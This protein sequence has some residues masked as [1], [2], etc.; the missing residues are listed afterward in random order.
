ME[1]PV[2]NNDLANEADKYLMEGD[3][4]SAKKLY[5]EILS[6]DP[7]NWRALNGLGLITSSSNAQSSLDYFARAVENC[8][9]S[10]SPF[11]NLGV[12][13][14]K[15]GQGPKAVKAWET[16]IERLGRGSKSI[17]LL[18]ALGL[19]YL[20]GSKD[21]DKANEYFQS[22]REIET[23][24]KDFLYYI[25]LIHEE[26]GNLEK[27]EE[28]YLNSKTFNAYGNL[29]LL[30]RSL[31]RH[32]ES[33]TAFMSALEIEDSYLVR[34]SLAAIYNDLDDSENA[35]VNIKAG[36]T[37]YPHSGHI[38]RILRKMVDSDEDSADVLA[39]LA[40]SESQGRS[41]DKAIS[42]NS[43]RD[44]YDIIND[45]CCPKCFSQLVFIKQSLIER[46]R[47]FYD[48]VETACKNCG[49]VK[50]FWFSI[51]SFFP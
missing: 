36:L 31:N 10:E 40:E 11:I 9:E 8:Y 5:E 20:F 16:G 23:E 38:K 39:L 51:Q 3:H 19:E 28:F 17:H 2:D 48:I 4:E 15:L 7:D 25:G 12:A 30:Y 1:N 14:S 34:F 45:D 37:Q 33:I 32:S 42:V 41:K 22:A 27:A 29:G 6:V 24:N 49:E 47:R 13:Y 44:E 26:K 18:K 21:L 46:E 43:V 35:M 50:D